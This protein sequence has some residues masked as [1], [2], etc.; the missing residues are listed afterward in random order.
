MEVYTSK[1]KGGFWKVYIQVWA[2]NK[3]KGNCQIAKNKGWYAVKNEERTI[4]KSIKI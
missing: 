4:M 3:K 2:E 1:M